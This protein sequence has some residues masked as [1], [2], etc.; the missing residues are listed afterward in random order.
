MGDEGEDL[1]VAGICA[2]PREISHGDLHSVCVCVC[3]CVCEMKKGKKGEACTCVCARERDGKEGETGES[4]NKRTHVSRVTEQQGG[5]SCPC[6]CVLVMRLSSHLLDDALAAPVVHIHAL[7]RDDDVH[8]C[9]FQAEL[10][11]LRE[12][13]RVK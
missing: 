10:A 8:G 11:D 1:L 6:H 3:V 13:R 2:D 4:L 12:G 5:A 7:V 9:G